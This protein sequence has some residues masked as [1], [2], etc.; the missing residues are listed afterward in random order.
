ML[1]SFESFG[2]HAAFAI[3]RYG[4]EWLVSFAALTEGEDEFVSLEIQ[5]KL[6]WGN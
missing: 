5:Y 4:T 1:I 6:I 3:T 2:G